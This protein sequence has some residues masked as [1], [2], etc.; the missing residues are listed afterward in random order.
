MAASVGL[1]LWATHWPLSAGLSVLL[2]VY[3]WLRLWMAY[4][5]HCLLEIYAVRRIDCIEQ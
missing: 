4:P 1:L 2:S 3:T 5:L